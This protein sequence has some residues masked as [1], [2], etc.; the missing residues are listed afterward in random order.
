MY[1]VLPGVGSGFDAPVGTHRGPDGGEME[2]DRPDFTE[3]THAVGKGRVQI[4]AGYTF[5]YGRREGATTQ[6]HTFPELLLRIGMAED[7][8]LRLS[9]PGG[10]FTEIH[11]RIRTPAGRWVGRTQHFDG[12]ADMDLGFKLHLTDQ[13]NMV[14]DLGVIGVLSLPTGERT[15][16][17]GDVDPEVKWLWA[18]E[19][20]ERVSLAG[21]VN[22]AVP[23]SEKGRF[24]QTSASF[25][26]G[27]SLAEWV[28]AYVEYFGFY[29]NDRGGEC[30][31]YLN[32]G[33][34]FPLG[35][36]FQFDIRAGL[37]M[38]EEADD[39]FAGAGFAV[40]F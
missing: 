4:E 10:S 5:T 14:P 7:F 33:F 30:A 20:N 29:P 40:R 26:V 16:T 12:A 18:Y 34:T 8:E 17:S 21:N 23:T 22:L 13:D 6:D 25:S 9:W 24:F 35:T 39:V 15:K 31:H 1:F 3:G 27:V 36:D 19:L 11:D 28:G 38:N 37:G 32:G 2:T